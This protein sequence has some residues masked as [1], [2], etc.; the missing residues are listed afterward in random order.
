MSFVLFIVRSGAESQLY[1]I[2]FI[3]PISGSC[4]NCLNLLSRFI[5]L[6][7]I[8]QIITITDFLSVEFYIASRAFSSASFTLPLSLR[9]FGRNFSWLTLSSRI[10]FSSFSRVTITFTSCLS[11]LTRR[12]RAG[13]LPSRRSGRRCAPGPPRR[14]GRAGTPS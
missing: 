4:N 13:R 12:R 6:Q 1:S 8:Q 5:I 9:R 3:F 10:S 11:T 2:F 14:A 7:F